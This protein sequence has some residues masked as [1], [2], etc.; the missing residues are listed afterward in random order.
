MTLLVQKFGGTSVGSIDRIEAV[1]DRVM[2]TYQQGHQVVVVLSAM[3]GET[4][5]LLGLAKQIDEIPT[6]R[7][8][9]VLLSA[10]EQVSIAL[11][12]MALNRRGIKAQSLT[13]DQVT[14]RTDNV[15]NN[16][17]ITDV[18][19]KRLTTLLE[20]G[21]VVVVAGFQGRD[22]DNN[23]TTLGRGGSDMTAVAVAS[24]LNATECQIFTDV[25]GVYS[26]DPR[27]VPDAKRLNVIH[28]EHMRTMASK[29]AKVLQLQSVEYALQH[30]VPLRVLSSFDEGEGTLVNFDITSTSSI[31]G[32]AISGNQVLLDVEL[33]K[34][35]L[36][37]QLSLFGVEVWSVTA[38]ADSTQIVAS[39]DDLARL[40]LVLD[41]KM[42]HIGDVSTLSMIG[43][44]VL[45]YANEIRI[46]LSEA[47]IIV[48]HKQQQTDCLSLLI[49][50]DDHMLAVDIIH[51]RF[52]VDQQ[53]LDNLPLLAIY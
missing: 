4:N 24:A 23:I 22:S 21:N 48:H 31:V 37:R 17:S 52:V 8:L 45:E 34:D 39:N 42:R 16:A 14:I 36:Q 9:D 18:E 30:S 51:K 27:L 13:A 32:I 40:R 44:D 33:S 47:G 26:T 49:D 10:G 46:F 12:A 53:S 7:E 20:Q 15:F 3:A 25:D 6:A 5:R 19:T 1:A 35:E 50:K 29:G 41:E 43:N 11:L 38:K 28:F 2:K